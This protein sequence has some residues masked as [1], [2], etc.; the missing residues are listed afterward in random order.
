[1]L[2]ASSTTILFCEDLK[3]VVALDNG[4][5]SG[6]RTDLRRRGGVVRLPMSIGMSFVDR[7]L[8]CWLAVCPGAGSAGYDVVGAPR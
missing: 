4:G 6:S 5:D 1:M 3:S 8:A 2:P 7:Q